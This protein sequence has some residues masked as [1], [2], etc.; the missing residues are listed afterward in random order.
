MKEGEPI[1]GGTQANPGFASTPNPGTQPAI[2]AAPQNNI[3][4][5]SP[6]VPIVER[7]HFTPS[8]TGDIL[9]SSQNPKE[10]SKQKKI[11]LFLGA[12]VALVVIAIIFLMIFTKN[13]SQDLVS[14]Y[15]PYAE[16]IIFGTDGENQ[17]NDGTFNISTDT[18]I[19]IEEAETSP[20]DYEQYFN[21]L[22]EKFENLQ[23]AANKSSN[24][25]LINTLAKNKGFLD[26]Y[27]LSSRVLY[28]DMLFNAYFNDSKEDLQKE[29]DEI[30]SVDGEILPNYFTE[31]LK[32]YVSSQLQYYDAINNLGCI[33]FG[34][35]NY[36]CVNSFSDELADP[37]MIADENYV[38]LR[39]QNESVYVDFTDTL[40]LIYEDIK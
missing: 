25:N 27:I 7:P 31:S 10:T 37:I 8:G 40:K 36:S 5:P 20:E 15:D 14:V 32:E 18:Y 22:S 2:P 3:S 4:T 24:S 23:D 35:I 28:S 39:D 34:G 29:I 11:F 19:I 26:F 1:L 21:S 13:P 16:F 33:E 12:A 6:T 9:L 38:I 17:I 30:S